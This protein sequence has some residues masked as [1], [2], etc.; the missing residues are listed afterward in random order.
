[1]SSRTGRISLKEEREVVFPLRLASKLCLLFDLCNNYFLVACIF[2]SLECNNVYS[3]R[4][5]NS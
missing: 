1:M 4:N 5:I 2:L 3:W